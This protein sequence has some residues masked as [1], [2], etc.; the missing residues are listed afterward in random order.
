MVRSLRLWTSPIRARAR[1][2]RLDNQISDGRLTLRRYGQAAGRSSRAGLTPGAG[3]VPSYQTVSLLIRCICNI[4][5]REGGAFSTLAW[6]DPLARCMEPGRS[7]PPPDKEELVRYR[8]SIG[9]ATTSASAIHLVGYLLAEKTRIFSSGGDCP[10][11][12]HPSRAERRQTQVKGVL[13]WVWSATP[14]PIASSPPSITHASPGPRSDGVRQ[15]TRSGSSASRRPSP[16]ARATRL[17]R[18][19]LRPLAAADSLPVG[20]GSYCAVSLQRRASQH[21][22][23]VSTPLPRAATPTATR[24][25]RR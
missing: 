23:L 25:P 21:W 15:R 12:Q 6:C 16:P 17:T 11:A 2:T 24:A 10:W 8:V 7:W 9:V 20:C 22:P 4:A 5:A 14:R 19:K 3:A 1:P 18:P 13:G